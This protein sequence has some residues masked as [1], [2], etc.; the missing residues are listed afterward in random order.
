M[1]PNE[2]LMGDVF[3]GTR[4]KLAAAVSLL[5]QAEIRLY[6]RTYA[7]D[8]VDSI[9]WS[10]WYDDVASAIE[11]VQNANR[12]VREELARQ[13]SASLDPT[14]AQTVRKS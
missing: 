7:S 9:T 6:Q 5:V 10:H 4:L 1:K 12:E 3:V 8:N 14:S 11:I 13:I 2:A